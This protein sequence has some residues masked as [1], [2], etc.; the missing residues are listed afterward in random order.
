MCNCYF[1]AASLKTKEM[2]DAIRGGRTE[3]LT[4]SLE[5]EKEYAKNGLLVVHTLKIPSQP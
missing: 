1:N 4:E 2:N 5:K 3:G